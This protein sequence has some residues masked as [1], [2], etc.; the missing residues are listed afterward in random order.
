[1]RKT[2][3]YLVSVGLFVSIL[4]S[5]VGMSFAQMPNG[6]EPVPVRPCN[7]G[8]PSDA[9]DQN[10][11]SNYEEWLQNRTMDFW[12]QDPEVVAI[13]QNGER[14][15]QLLWW[16][17]SH[18]SLDTHPSIL[19]VWIISRNITYFLLILATV[20]VGLGIIIGQK[21]NFNLKINVSNQL[22][23]V[24]LLLLYITFSATFVILLIQLSDIVMQFFIK[25]LGAD[26]IFNIFFTNADSTSYLAA[27][28]KGY[29]DIAATGCSNLSLRASE[30]VRFSKFMI[31]F[32]NLTYF[33]IAI[34]FIL[35]KVILWFMLIAS[36]FLAI[37]FPFSITHNTGILWIRLFIQWLFYGPIFGLFLGGLAKMWD[38]SNSIPFQFNFQRIGQE[39][40]FVFPTAISISYNGPSIRS[41]TDISPMI[42]S[43]YIDTFAEY[44]I[45]LIMLWV[46]IVLPWFLLRTF[47]DYC[48]DGINSIKNILLSNIDN[49]K[50][51]ISPQKPPPP[52]NNLSAKMNMD[53]SMDNNVPIKTKIDNI[54][55]IKKANTDEIKKAMQISAS[56]IVD[57]A[58]LEINSG[59]KDAA[60]KSIE[61]LKNPM[62]AQTPTERQQY[63]HLRSELFDRA[64]KGDESARRTLSAI[65]S[66]KTEQ[67]SQ[68][69]ELLNSIPVSQPI[70]IQAANRAGVSKEKVISTFQT[71]Y[72]SLSESEEAMS[73][74]STSANIPREQT[75]LI[76]KSLGKSDNLSES[77]DKLVRN[78]SSDTGITD[79]KVKEMIEKLAIYLKE[80]QK[81]LSDIAI[82]ENIS[83]DS[84]NKLILA[85][86]PTLSEPQKNLEESISL[87][88]N[89]SIEEYEQ[90]KNMWINHYEKGEVPVSD[91]VSNRNE[92]INGD[93]INIT[94]ILNKLLSSDNE[95]KK[96]ALDE[97]NYILPI[98]L[99]NDL[100][101]G[102]LLVYLK[103]K[104]EAAKQVSRLLEK[105]KEIQEQMKSQDVLVDIPIVA[106]KEEE[107]TMELKEEVK[108]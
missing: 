60:T 13:G 72:N 64:T 37:L 48:C 65:A 66:N 73:T 74:L 7:S 6:A 17:F 70:F 94:N 42:S 24:A 82:K 36:P 77:A 92:W 31:M 50:G 101:G 44:V 32:T 87:P 9:L 35:R 26:K 76:L 25:S 38:S 78:I 27:S 46:V 59:L 22:L 79:V 4:V 57:V 108:L 81:G 95:M 62:S 56:K 75:K 1:M 102:E 34:I 33:V 55:E 41:L 5:S 106:K 49:F 84:L 45:S 16:V 69:Q 21:N 91:T 58:N 89:V 12:V 11:A 90:I 61:Y 52:A 18:N 86:L 63:M 105:E 47:Q 85:Y 67:N 15:K 8:C 28:E 88:S 103:A 2:I 97:V 83:E 43:N 80:N 68:K 30:S 93:S 98:F 51:G 29:R 53:I 71:F 39:T 96:K 14:A 10:C 100:K 107:K 3:L 54:D 19:A 99:I 40:S 20:L 104:L 23:K